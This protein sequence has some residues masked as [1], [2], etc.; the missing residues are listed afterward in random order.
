MKVE[1][2][3]ITEMIFGFLSGYWLFWRCLAH[4]VPQPKL[5]LSNIW[6]YLKKRRILHCFYKA[7]SW[8]FFQKGHLETPK[9]H[10]ETKLYYGLRC[11]NTAFCLLNYTVYP[12]KKLF[13]TSPPPVT[14]P[15]SFRSPTSLSLQ[16][17]SESNRVK[18]IIKK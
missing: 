2:F 11:K 16:Q 1:D 4:L 7:M 17:P 15:L 14:R 12:E 18:K 3:C 8:Q 13:C 5:P 10:M 6:K 9:G